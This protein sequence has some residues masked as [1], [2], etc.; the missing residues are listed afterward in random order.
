LKPN[1]SAD[2]DYVLDVTTGCVQ[3]AING[4]TAAEKDAHKVY[5]NPTYTD[6]KTV[7]DVFANCTVDFAQVKYHHD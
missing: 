6:P 3:G 1:T 7:D 2:P 4:L 5:N